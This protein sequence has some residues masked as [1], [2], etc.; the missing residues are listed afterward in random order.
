MLD[1]DS[2][3]GLKRQHVCRSMEEELK[4][5]GALVE[6]AVTQQRKH[7]LAADSLKDEQGHVAVSST[8]GVEEREL[9]GTMDVGIAFVK[10]DDDY[11]RLHVI[12]FHKMLEE[13]LANG[14]Q[15][16]PAD[17]VLT[18]Q[19]GQTSQICHVV[20]CKAHLNL[21]FYVKQPQKVCLDL[22]IS[23]N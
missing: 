14:I 5:V 21:L 23:E 16:T 18:A 3:L 2:L 9:P 17:M 15:L 13:Q 10:V 4:L 22:L 20:V 6:T 12:G 8:I 1:K 19:N 7:K 11:L